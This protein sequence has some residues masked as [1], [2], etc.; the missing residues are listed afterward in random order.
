MM[1]ISSQPAESTSNQT[2][3]QTAAGNLE[4][5][6]PFEIPVSTGGADGTIKG[7]FHYGFYRP[8]DRTSILRR[9]NLPPLIWPNRR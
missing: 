4:S 1:Q 9:D 5:G 3:V 7:E 8:R 2:A 6:V